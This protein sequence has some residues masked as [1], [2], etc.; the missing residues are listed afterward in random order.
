MRLGGASSK[1]FSCKWIST[2]QILKAYREHG[3]RTNILKL[4]ARYPAKI[5]E[6]VLILRKLQS[7]QSINSF[8]YKPYIYPLLL[9]HQETGQQR[10]NL[11]DKF[12]EF[13]LDV[14]EMESIN[15]YKSKSLIFHSETL[16]VGSPKYVRIK[17]SLMFC[18]SFFG[19]HVQLSK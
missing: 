4:F 11:L 6:R 5:L 19:R 12:E 16:K 9:I 7:S 18:S 3:I 2:R 15:S 10:S 8:K 13:K 1:N 17:Q 14:R